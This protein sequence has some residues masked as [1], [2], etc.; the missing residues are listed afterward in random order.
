MDD[1]VFQDIIAIPQ[2]AIF[3]VQVPQING[4]PW[5]TVPRHAR[6]HRV[7]VR[8]FRRLTSRSAKR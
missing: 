2:L 3:D 7:K 5:N 1:T 4:K 6:S 8:W